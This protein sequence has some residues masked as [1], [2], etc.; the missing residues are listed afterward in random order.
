MTP[1]ALIDW[2]HENDLNCFMYTRDQPGLSATTDQAILSGQPLLTL[3]NATFRHIH[4]YIPPYPQT[5]SRSRSRARGLPSRRCSTTGQERRAKF[6]RM[7]AVCG[8]PVEG[9]GQTSG[10]GVS[11]S[12]ATKRDKILVLHQVDG[13]DGDIL[14]YGTRFSNALARSATRDIVRKACDSVDAALVTCFDHAPDVVIVLD[15]S[16]EWFEGFAECCRSWRRF[17][18]LHGRA[19]EG[20]N[21]P[22]NALRSCLSTRTRVL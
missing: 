3:T 6:E 7:L 12:V 14:S 5:P 1:E 16:N 8:L 17:R 10:R 13:A 2:C 20:P 22:A 9:I 4:P 18:L 15:H 21:G 11:P 19:I